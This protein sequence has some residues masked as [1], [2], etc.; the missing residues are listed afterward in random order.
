MPEA[1]QHLQSI[2]TILGKFLPEIAAETKDFGLKT[3]NAL[4]DVGAQIIGVQE[5]ID[6][7]T[8]A[9]RDLT[10]LVGEMQVFPRQPWAKTR[11]VI[12]WFR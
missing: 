8:N 11:R 10:A 9:V 6:E 2:A 5:S 3:E 4:T 7:L 12:G 1:D